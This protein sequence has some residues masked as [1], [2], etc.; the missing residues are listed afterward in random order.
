MAWS[1]NAKG[2][3]E[4]CAAAIEA[5]VAPDDPANAQHFELARSVLKAELERYEP[6]S[7]EML[8]AASGHVP[9]EG[10]SDR[11]F[12]IWIS[13]KAAPHVE[14]KPAPA[15]SEPSQPIPPLTTRRGR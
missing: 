3:R 7:S 4:E 11:S 15:Q 10:Y 8:I 12:S 2:T 13:G 6:R 5:G 14:A 1:I 9:G